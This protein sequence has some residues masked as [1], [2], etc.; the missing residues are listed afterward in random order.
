MN[1]GDGIVFRTA[2]ETR[3]SEVTSAPNYYYWPATGTLS[4]FAYYPTDLSF[5]DS[6]APN[7]SL[8]SYTP[9]TN[10]KDQK[11]VIMAV[12]K[13][14]KADEGKSIG[15]HF[16]HQLQIEVKAKNTNS[17]YVFSVKGMKIGSVAGSGDLSATRRVMPVS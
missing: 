4:F 14:S 3:A 9:V 6:D 12:A 10:I 16:Y 13:G 11:D 1:M 2:I 15:L 7:L 5:E 17:A 8:K